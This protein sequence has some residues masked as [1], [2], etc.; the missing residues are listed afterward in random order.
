MNNSVPW[1][2]CCFWGAPLDGL[3]GSAPGEC[4]GFSAFSSLPPRPFPCFLPSLWVSLKFLCQTLK[5]VQCGRAPWHLCWLL[6]VLWGGWEPL[7]SGSQDDTLGHYTASS[8]ADQGMGLLPGHMLRALWLP[9]NSAFF[10]FLMLTQHCSSFTSHQRVCTFHCELW[11]E[12]IYYRRRGN[13]HSSSGSG[14]GGSGSGGSGP[15]GW[16]G[17]E[18][19]SWQCCISAQIA[20]AG[21]VENTGGGPEPPLHESPWAEGPCRSWSLWLRWLLLPPGDGHH[22]CESQPVPRSTLRCARGGVRR[23]GP[24]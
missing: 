19:W 12:Q 20:L 5:G 7:G 8:H 21:D 18:G 15:G 10:S 4:F 24:T 17:S 1:E 22:A 13:W 3:S 16:V 23:H 9:T 14:P 2:S 11:G 6:S